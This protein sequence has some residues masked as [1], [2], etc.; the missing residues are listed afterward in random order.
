M[1]RLPD[2]FDWKTSPGHLAL[3]KAFARPREVNQVLDWQ[4]LRDQVPEPVMS[5]IERL[6]REG[7]LVSPSVEEKVSFRF[8]VP[9]LKDLLKERGIKGVD[10]KEA[11]V[12][13]LVVADR[14]GAESLVESIELLV[15]SDS[16]MQVMRELEEAQEAAK[17][18]AQE[19][20]FELLL[21]GEPA[22]AFWAHRKYSKAYEQ[23][24]LSDHEGEQLGFL[25]RKTP[26]MLVEQ[27]S[28]ET[29]RVIRALAGMKLLWHQFPFMQRLPDGLD[30]D[31]ETLNNAIELLER[32][33]EVMR[34]LSRMDA[35][36]S[37]EIVFSDDDILVCDNCRDFNGRKYLVSEFPDWPFTGCEN[38]SGCIPELDWHPGNGIEDEEDESDVTGFYPNT[39]PLES[40]RQLKAMFDEGLITEQ[41]FQ[42]KKQEILSRM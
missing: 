14:A 38:E 42:D 16:A 32:H 11:M 34:D 12:K 23:Y 20:E 3:L 2:S 39:T 25:F 35:T 7:A 29:F 17:R 1:A 13:A 28:E 36:D 18:K 37:V 27:L 8:K 31:R 5:G 41:D 6:K 22:S 15:M 21:R 24:Q 40:L 33:A 26:K 19:Q 4:F 30:I 9:E 10:G